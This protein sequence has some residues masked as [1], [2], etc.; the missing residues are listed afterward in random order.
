MVEEVP[1]DTLILSWRHDEQGQHY[2][3]QLTTAG[4]AAVA[5]ARSQPEQTEPVVIAERCPRSPSL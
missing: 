1:T 3:L 5:Q 4:L 2:A